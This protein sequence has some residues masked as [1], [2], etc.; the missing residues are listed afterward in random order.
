MCNGTYPP[1]VE[2]SR[3][4]CDLL[5]SSVDILEVL[6]SSC[7]GGDSSLCL[8]G[9]VEL[10]ALRVALFLQVVTSAP[11]ETRQNVRLVVPGSAGCCSFSHFGPGSI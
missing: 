8:L 6:G 5:E 1:A 2:F 3:G 4:V 10:S 7:S 9:P 11:V